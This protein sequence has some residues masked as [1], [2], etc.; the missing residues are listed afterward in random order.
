MLE[1][2]REYELFE[3]YVDAVTKRIL[4]SKKRNEIHD[5]LFSHFIEEYERYTALGLDHDSA[6]EK[7]IEAMGD[8]D[9]LSKQFGEIYS[10]YSVDYMRSSLNYLIGGILFSTFHIDLF[11]TGFSAI[12]DFFGEALLIYGLFLLR[13]TDIKLNITL[14][15]QIIIRLFSLIVNIITMNMANVGDFDVLCG[16]FGTIPMQVI[17]FGFMFA[18]IDSLCKTL[19][20]EK[21]PKPKMV[22]SFISYAMF[23]GLAVFATIAEAPELGIFSPIMII[24]PLWQLRNAKNVLGNGD[25]EFELKETLNSAEK[26]TYWTIIIALIIVPIISM[27]VISLSE[28]EVAPYVQN[29]TNVETAGVQNARENMLRLGFPEEYLND[30]PNSEI[31]RYEKAIYM[32]EQEPNEYN[33]KNDFGFFKTS[34]KDQQYTFTFADGEIRTM[35]RVELPDDTRNKNRLGLYIEYWDNYIICTNG[36]D[37]FQIALSDYRGK[38]VTSIPISTY[39]ADFDFFTGGFEFKFPDKASNCR[40]YV[41]KTAVVTRPV[42]ELNIALNG[43]FFY[44]KFPISFAYQSINNLA[45]KVFKNNAW[46]FGSP[47]DSVGEVQLYHT[48]NFHPEFFGLEPEVIEAEEQ[49]Q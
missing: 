43:G 48:L 9:E 46:V 24:I 47:S 33:I 13:K 7:I 49:I 45:I 14:V 8:K 22:L 39:T 3:Q 4:S 26:G 18:G 19:E 42:H 36:N 44:E 23:S 41:S 27:L 17:A 40:A 5:E 35:T 32:I 16:I 21:L 30:L 2:N 29:D 37:D 20:A 10:I 28:P 12:T 1:E 6:Q 15:L 38:T 11:F 34:F 31:V 25:E